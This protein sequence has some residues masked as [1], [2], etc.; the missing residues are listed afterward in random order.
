MWS[1]SHSPED[2]FYSI[3]SIASLY[4]YIFLLEDPE[5]FFAYYYGKEENRQIPRGGVPLMELWVEKISPDASSSESVDFLG[6]TK[7]FHS[8]NNS[9]AAPLYS[10]GTT[11]RMACER[12]VRLVGSWHASRDLRNDD[13]PSIVS[14]AGELKELISEDV[15]NQVFYVMVARLANSVS[16][17]V[18]IFWQ[19]DKDSA[20]QSVF[21]VTDP[22]LGDVVIRPVLQER[23]V[24]LPEEYSSPSNLQIDMIKLW[25]K[26]FLAEAD[27]RDPLTFGLLPGK[28][29][30]NISTT[31]R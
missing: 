12:A 27:R 6:S 9:T 1:S 3:S 23:I 29:P 24:K 22:D 13:E 25:H 28:K 21:C 7:V 16:V 30:I 10:N 8:V 4:P 11:A 19:K 2:P 31:N 14:V 17:A 20:W 15:R 18:D 26:V 5:G